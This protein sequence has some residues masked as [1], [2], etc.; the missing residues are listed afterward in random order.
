MGQKK[1][2]TL[3]EWMKAQKPS[4]YRSRWVE[5]DGEKYQSAEEAKRHGELKLLERAGKISRLERQPRYVLEQEYRRPDGKW[6]RAECYIADFAYIEDGQIVVEDVK[7]G[8][9]TQT[10]IFR[11][12][13]KR[14]R[15]KYPDIDARI[16]G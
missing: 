13:W 8:R 7:G 12:K 3:D 9:A 14:F 5:I 6:E 2:L 1:P 11:S 15:R 4:K 16:V 10:A